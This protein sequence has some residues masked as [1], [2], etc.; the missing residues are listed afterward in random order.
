MLLFD[1]VWLLDTTM[2][3][4]LI[5]DNNE[6][7]FMKWCLKRANHIYTSMYIHSPTLDLLHLFTWP[8]K[9]LVNQ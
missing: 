5:C 2:Y 8:Y 9:M 7:E 3:Y 6:A 4:F 1:M